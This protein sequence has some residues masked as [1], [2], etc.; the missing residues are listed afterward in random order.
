M[1]GHNMMHR[2]S[3]G[4]SHRRCGSLGGGDA[5]LTTTDIRRR[6]AE[7]ATA[8]AL[9]LRAPPLGPR[10]RGC[11]GVARAGVDDHGPCQILATACR[12]Q[13]RKNHAL[14]RLGPFCVRDDARRISR[15]AANRRYTRV[16]GLQ[17]AGET[18]REHAA[19]R[20]CRTSLTT[21]PPKHLA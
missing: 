6:P 9:R 5:A 2:S 18:V 17:R 20:H 19:R 21:R 3:R 12:R 14:C 1:E 10:K 15:V 13:R 16:R 4:P 11:V 8:Q 7:T